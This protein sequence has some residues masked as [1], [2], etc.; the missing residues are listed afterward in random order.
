[1]RNVDP[2]LK[3]MVINFAGGLT[4]TVGEGFN[5]EDWRSRLRTIAWCEREL[6]RRPSW[7][8]YTKPMGKTGYR[9]EH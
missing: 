1:M 7:R 6:A 5:R 3:G 8:H 4:Y 2:R 9:G